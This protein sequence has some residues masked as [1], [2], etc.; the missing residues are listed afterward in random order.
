MHPLRFAVA[1]TLNYGTRCGR[2]E[3]CLRLERLGV[4]ETSQG[5]LAG[6]EQEKQL[7]A[8]KANVCTANTRAFRNAKNHSKTVSN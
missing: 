2:R 1:V 6:N 4:V 8:T 7:T 3:G 5:M